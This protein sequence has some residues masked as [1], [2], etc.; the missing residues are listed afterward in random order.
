[1]PIV[2]MIVHRIVVSADKSK[3]SQKHVILRPYK[4]TAE[5]LI[6]T[7]SKEYFTLRYIHYYAKVS[8]D[9]CVFIKFPNFSRSIFCN[10]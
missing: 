7:D 2:R 4:I 6:R 8:C 5:S 3:L 10:L 1:M 9:L